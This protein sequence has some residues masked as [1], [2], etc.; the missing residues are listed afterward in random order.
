[1]VADHDE[2][3]TSTAAYADESA[4]T[5][6]YDLEA[7]KWLVPAALVLFAMLLLEIVVLFAWRSPGETGVFIR[8][9]QAGIVGF[10]LACGWAKWW[11]RWLTAF[12]AV[13]AFSLTMLELL[14]PVAFIMFGVLIMISAGFTYLVRMIVAVIRGESNPTQRFT[15]FGLMIVTAIVAVC[16]MGMSNLAEF[17][18]PARGASMVIM[19]A[20]FGLSLIVQCAL[21][22]TTTRRQAIAFGGSALSLAFIMPF[23][24]YGVIFL[25]QDRMPPMSRVLVPCW[26]MVLTTWVT[27]YPLVFVFYGMGGSLIN[28]SWK[29]KPRHEL[30]VRPAKTETDVDVL[31]GEYGD[32]N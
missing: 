7:T 19:M 28:P 3:F 15:I 12:A 9:G 11:V 25:S 18:E 32:G 2:A 10:Y 23:A 24:I 13:L 5:D 22:W 16:A 29:L 21:L 20:F 6:P 17:Q 4:S 27:L 31:M 26:L 1:M 30:A 8:F 14:D